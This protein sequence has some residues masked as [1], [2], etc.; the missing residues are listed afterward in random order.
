M[1]QRAKGVDVLA[2]QQLEEPARNPDLGFTRGVRSQVPGEP[3]DNV[4]DG[5]VEH[6]GVVVVL[7]APGLV[8]L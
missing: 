6:G 5:A 7:Q 1:S 3:V 8:L 4:A 2:V